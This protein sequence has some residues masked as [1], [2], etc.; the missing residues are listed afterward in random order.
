LAIPSV[1]VYVIGPEEFGLLCSRSC[2][3]F[4]QTDD[5]LPFRTNLAAEYSLLLA[6]KP[7][8]LGLAT[9]AVAVIAQASMA[10]CFPRPATLDAIDP[11][12]T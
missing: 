5:T 10:S 2:G 7:L 1:F 11:P 8:G 6:K 3:W 12:L 9:E 4:F